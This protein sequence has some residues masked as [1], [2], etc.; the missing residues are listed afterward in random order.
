[1][2]IPRLMG[3]LETGTGVAT[4]GMSLTT[5]SP[6]MVS[7]GPR[8]STPRSLIRDLMMV[9]PLRST[10]PPGLYNKTGEPGADRLHT[11]SFD[12]LAVASG[13]GHGVTAQRE[14]ARREGCFRGE[15]TDTRCCQAR[16]F[17]GRCGSARVTAL[18]D[19]WRTAARDG[20]SRLRCSR[21]SLPV[22]GTAVA[23]LTVERQGQSEGEE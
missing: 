1:M 16:G 5:I 2:T 11:S 20:W 15:G 13:C 17:R 9:L 18:P 12:R 3:V 23:K 19:C 21:D 6:A 4:E 14:A 10:Y 22:V 8:Q 7:C